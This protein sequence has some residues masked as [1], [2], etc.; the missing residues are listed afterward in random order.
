MKMKEIEH[1]L[2][3]TMIYLSGDGSRHSKSMVLDELNH[4][5]LGVR[6]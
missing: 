5:I 1:K 6:I 2:D 4:K 3:P